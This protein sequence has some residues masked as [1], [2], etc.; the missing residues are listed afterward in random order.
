M[1]YRRVAGCLLLIACLVAVSLSA[2]D[3]QSNFVPGDFGPAAEKL[4]IGQENGYYDLGRM[5]DAALDR[6]EQ[7]EA[8]VRLQAGDLMAVSARAA[9][10]EARLA[11][12]SG[13]IGNAVEALSGRVEQLEAAPSIPL[14]LLPGDPIQRGH[15]ATLEF[16]TLLG[17]SVSYEIAVIYLATRAFAKDSE[18]R[19]PPQTDGANTIWWSW[20]CGTGQPGPAIA[21]VTATAASVVYRACF[22]FRVE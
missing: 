14:V 15:R 21:V 1:N 6:S 13:S 8:R 5:L 9:D 20:D 3:V 4:G 18:L 22:E 7:L 12:Q 19:R 11:E 17:P 2:G 16:H 10:L